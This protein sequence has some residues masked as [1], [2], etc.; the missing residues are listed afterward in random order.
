[1]L[2]IGQFAANVSTE[3]LKQKDSIIYHEDEGFYSGYFG[4]TRP[5]TNALYGDFYLVEALTE[6]N[7]PLDIDYRERDR[8][9]GRQ[10]KAYCRAVLTT[11]SAAMEQKAFHAHSYALFRAFSNIESS[12][13]DLYRLNEEPRPA[14]ADEI[15]G[16]LNAAIDFIND[17]IEVIDK[18]G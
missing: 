9:D 1:R 5:F 12:A 8:F 6:G 10:F 3:A 16:R 15:S 14:D 13:T 17:A 18:A 4:Y 7:G 11:F 2:S